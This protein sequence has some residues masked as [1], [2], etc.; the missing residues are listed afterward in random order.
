MCSVHGTVLVVIQLPAITASNGSGT[1]IIMV[2]STWSV[3]K[4]SKGS[5]VAEREGEPID[6]K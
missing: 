3:R 2:P 6:I 4:A 5:G 1:T